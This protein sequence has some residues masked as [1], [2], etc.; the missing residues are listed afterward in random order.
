MSDETFDRLLSEAGFSTTSI[1]DFLGGKRSD[2][3]IWLVIEVDY[4]GQIACTIP[5]EFLK[6]DLTEQLVDQVVDQL[7][8]FL[9]DDMDGGTCSYLAHPKDFSRGVI[10]GMGGGALIVGSIWGHLQFSERKVEEDLYRIISP[11]LKERTEIV[12]S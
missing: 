1:H 6:A 2:L 12:F 9:W 7:Q 11:I 5:A 10:G 3:P 4:G 8:L